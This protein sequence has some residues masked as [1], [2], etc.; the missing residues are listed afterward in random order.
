MYIL[1]Y[2]CYEMWNIGFMSGN[3]HNKKSNVPSQVQPQKSSCGVQTLAHSGKRP[4][5]CW[6]LLFCLCWFYFGF[7]CL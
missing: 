5:G 2:M 7:G 6:D 4:V 1:S 3:C